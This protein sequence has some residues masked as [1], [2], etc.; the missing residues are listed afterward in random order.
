MFCCLLVSSQKVQRKLLAEPS[1]WLC[2]ACVE[3]RC[4]AHC[5]CCSR[6]FGA[7]L[8]AKNMDVCSLARAPSAL[9]RC[10]LRAFGMLTSLEV[11]CLCNNVHFYITVT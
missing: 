3:E 4:G 9:Q 10:G 7:C 8:C 6:V 1:G 2:W 5:Y 11:Y